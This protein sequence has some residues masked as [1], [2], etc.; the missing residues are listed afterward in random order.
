MIHHEHEEKKQKKSD[1]IGYMVS[2]MT[3]SHSSLLSCKKKKKN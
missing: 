1:A 3:K 2:N